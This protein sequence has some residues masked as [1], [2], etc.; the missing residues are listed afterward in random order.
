MSS[1]FNVYDELGLDES[2]SASELKRQLDK[3]LEEVRRDYTAAS[4]DEERDAIDDRMVKIKHGRDIF[5]SEESKAEYDDELRAAIQQ[6]SES[7]RIKYGN[8]RMTDKN[9]IKLLNDSVED[10]DWQQVLSITKVMEERECQDVNYYNALARYHISQGNN[11]KAFNLIQTGIDNAGNDSFLILLKSCIL[12][13]ISCTSVKDTDLTTARKCADLLSEYADHMGGYAEVL[14]ISC[15]L[16]QQNYP[17]FHQKVQNFDVKYSQSKAARTQLSRDIKEYIDYKTVSHSNGVPYF[18]TD[19]DYALYKELMPEAIRITPEKH[20]E[21]QQELE[22][23]EEKS[24]IEGAWWGLSGDLMY[25]AVG[26]FAPGGFQFLGAFFLLLFGVT[27]YMLY[28]P[29]WHKNYYEATG[30]LKGINNVFRI[31]NVV[32]GKWVQIIVKFYKWFFG[33]FFGWFR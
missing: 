2:L 18:E 5:R 23:W 3:A 10:S 16:L 33:L 6:E 14:D 12:L 21:W 8:G 29:R 11:E 9:L 13:G 22:S 31:I 17:L 25:S 15:D 28:V 20:D 30:S 27:L 32:L 4:T 1:Y 26:W 7:Q 24:L 19:E